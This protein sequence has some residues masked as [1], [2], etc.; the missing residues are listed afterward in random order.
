MQKIFQE[1]SADLK[2]K[3]A[4][5]ELLTVSKE[6]ELEIQENMETIVR[7]EGLEEVFKELEED[8]VTYKD[9]V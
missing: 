6:H 4:S 1:M 7:R 5:G 9:V 3:A 2:K 8:K